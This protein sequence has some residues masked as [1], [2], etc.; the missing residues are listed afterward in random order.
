MK[1]LENLCHVL[2]VLGVALVLIG[3]TLIFLGLTQPSSKITVIDGDTVKMHD[4]R[5]RLLGFDT[6][7]MRARCAKEHT[8]ARKA[9]ARL[10]ALI[11]NSH[12]VVLLPS[13]N[14]DRYG[15]GLAKLTIDGRNVG[16]TLISEQLARPYRGGYR[17]SWCD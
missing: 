1:K 6:P 8:K 10:K 7:E 4:Q 9:T 17:K 12:D 13:G 16:D 3:G 5:F 15:R 14:Y 11:N 2:I